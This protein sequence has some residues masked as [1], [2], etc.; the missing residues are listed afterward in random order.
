MLLLIYIYLYFNFIQSNKIQY[1]FTLQGYTADFSWNYKIY[2]QLTVHVLQPF[3]P[4]LPTLVDL[5]AAMLTHSPD[6]SMEILP[7]LITGSPRR[8]AARI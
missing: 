1:I 3:T 4:G 8:L 6:A 7:F 5:W 2:I